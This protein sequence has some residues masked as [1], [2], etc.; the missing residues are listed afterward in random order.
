MTGPVA[1]EASA[2]YDNDLRIAELEVN[3]ANPITYGYDDDSLLTSAGALGLG[4]SIENGQLTSTE[5]STIDSAVTY[6][7]FGEVEEDSY[8]ESSNALLSISY[9]RDDAGRITQKTESDGSTTTTWNYH[10]DTAGRLDDVDLNGFAYANYVYDSNS[11]RTSLTQGGSTTT[12]TY[13]NQDRLLTRGVWDY[14][15]NLN[16]Q[17]EAK[18]DSGT[19]ATTAYAYDALGNL[20]SVN[21]PNTSN[22]IAYLTDGFGRRVGKK[23]GGNLEQ[24]WLYGPG[25]SGRW[26][27]QMT[28]AP[29]SAASSMPPRP[30]SPTTWSNPEPPTGSSKTSSAVRAWLSTPPLALWPR[31]SNTAPSARC[32]PTPT[33]AFSPSVSLAGSMTTRPG[34][35][36]S[37]PATTTPPPAAGPQPTRSASPAARP[38]FTAM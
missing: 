6:N 4:R 14:D 20:D 8:T 10:Y 9:V 22:D 36:A 37:A 29:S 11:N 17:L 26:P 12:S 5:L 28:R 3:G 33:P 16:G 1:G 27:K 7:D 15:Y 34:L 19:S 25:A 24:G 18:T 32:F 30:R 31:R 2:S 21:L 23:V 38:T 35:S 13:D